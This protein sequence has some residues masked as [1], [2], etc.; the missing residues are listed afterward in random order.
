MEKQ[1]KQQERMSSALWGRVGRWS[2]QWLPSHPSWC[3]PLWVHT[4]PVCC[5][6]R[7]HR[8]CTGHVMRSFPPARQALQPSDLCCWLRLTLPSPL[9]REDV[10]QPLPHL[11]QLG[12]VHFSNTAHWNIHLKKPQNKRRA[13][14]LY[15]FLFSWVFWCGLRF[16]LPLSFLL[17]AG[18]RLCLAS[19]QWFKV[20]RMQ[21]PVPPSGEDKT[22]QWGQET[23]RQSMP[24]SPLTTFI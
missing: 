22:L 13:Q 7:T 23:G 16:F 2:W 4:G 3:S 9:P 17:F 20:F 1:R 15:L 5:P 10:S 14:L 12:N 6:C 21:L 8:H 24:Q 19:L 18:A 11:S